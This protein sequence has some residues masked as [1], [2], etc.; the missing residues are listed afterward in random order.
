MNWRIQTVKF[1]KGK[2]AFVL[3]QPKQCRA[4]LAI[5]AIHFWSKPKE[6]NEVEDNAVNSDDNV[7]ENSSD[8]KVENTNEKK[9]DVANSHDNVN[10]NL[11][12][13]KPGDR[14]EMENN[15][16]NSDDNVNGNAN[17]A[18]ESKKGREMVEEEGIDESKDDRND[19]PSCR[20]P[21]KLERIDMEEIRERI[22]AE[23]NDER[24]E[25]VNKILKMKLVDEADVERLRKT[26]TKT[27]RKMKVACKGA[28]NQLAGVIEACNRSI[29]VNNLNP[30]T[31]RTELKDHFASC[32]T[33]T[34]IEFFKDTI[35]YRFL[36]M[37]SARIEFI[38]MLAKVKAMNLTDTILRGSK[39]DVSSFSSF[40]GKQS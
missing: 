4:A 20:A 13:S 28:Q 27:E 40:S 22:N 10:G 31:T 36:G 35:N 21:G 2:K 7:N 18:E 16:A 14:N 39:I 38:D 12:D 6:T 29:Y 23:R 8:S 11:G 17:G 19:S 37:N 5:F 1:G 15:V 25:D 32:G 24:M 9:D 30:R 3:D 34:A 33:I 26:I